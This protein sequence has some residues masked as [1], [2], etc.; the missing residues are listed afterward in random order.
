LCVGVALCVTGG[1]GGGG[2]GGG[3]RR[4]LGLAALH[5]GI[6]KIATQFYNPPPPKKAMMIRKGRL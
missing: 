6:I 2:G 5:R 4:M 1:V 3:G